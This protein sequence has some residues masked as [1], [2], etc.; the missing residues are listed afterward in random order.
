MWKSVHPFL[1][2][3][4]E[5]LKSSCSLSSGLCLALF[6]SLGAFQLRCTQ[7]RLE[8][9]CFLSLSPPTIA[10]HLLAFDYT[11]MLDQCFSRTVCRDS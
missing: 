2:L 4:W 1:F 7:N 8:T 9:G 3:V 10:K 11:N 5:L 6:C